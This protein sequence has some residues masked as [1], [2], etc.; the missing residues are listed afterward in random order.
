MGMK[1]SKSPGNIE[2]LRVYSDDMLTAG[3]KGLSR[4]EREAGLDRAIESTVEA[5]NRGEA[6]MYSLA[7]LLREKDMIARPAT[8]GEDIIEALG[9]LR[10]EHPVATG[11]AGGAGAV[12]AVMG[13]NKLRNGGE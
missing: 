10:R 11:A 1:I 2:A 3:G 9:R 4:A 7:G 8:A 13:L 12:G 5:I 6:D